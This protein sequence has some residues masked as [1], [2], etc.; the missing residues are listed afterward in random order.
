VLQVSGTASGTISGSAINWSANG[1]AT[2][3]GLSDCPVA[4]SGTALI[5]TN[6]IQVPYSGTTCMGPVSGTEVLTKKP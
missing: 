1:T 2:G 3:G 5:S 6:Q 4:L